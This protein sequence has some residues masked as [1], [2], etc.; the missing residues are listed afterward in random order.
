MSLGPRIWSRL[1]SRSR[2]RWGDDCPVGSPVPEAH[3][4]AALDCDSVRMADLPAGASGVVTCLEAPESAPAR[5]LASMGVLPGVRLELLRTFPAFVFRM[6][7]GE[8]AVDR[9]LAEHVRLRARREA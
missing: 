5:R 2:E 8:F 4:C 1:L 6:G 9:A 7:Y 3:R